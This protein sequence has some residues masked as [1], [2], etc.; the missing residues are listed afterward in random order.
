MN[1]AHS[2]SAMTHLQQKAALKKKRLERSEENLKATDGITLMLI[3]HNERRVFKLRINF[4]IVQFIAV[5]MAIVALSAVFSV[6]LESYTTDQKVKVMPGYKA[7]TNRAWLVNN[8]LERI[9]HKLDYLEAKGDQ[10]HK[11]IWPHLEPVEQPAATS[12]PG[13]FKKKTATLREALNLLS[14][15]AAVHEATPTGTPTYIGLVTSTY[16]QR[17]SPFGFVSDFHT[18]VDFA[19]ARGTP[20]YA[21]ADGVVEFAG[22]ND[23]G[24]GLYVKL[25]HK[26]GFESFYAHCSEI[27][28]EEGRQVKR[29]D[30]IALVGDT[31]TATGSHLHYEIRVVNEDVTG[32]YQLILNPW[33]FLKDNF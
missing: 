20:I 15:R 32:S 30:L 26:Y 27:K 9:Y 16:G 24:Y 7:S 8:A 17:I 11:E 23:S 22:G 12:L 5:V 25:R 6:A 29:G 31:G 21:T 18:G 13:V 33:P 1:S 10:L 2:Q 28:T 19:H 14:E 3:P 4:K